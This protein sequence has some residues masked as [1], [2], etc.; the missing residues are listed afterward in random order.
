VKKL[1]QG[2]FDAV[3]TGRIIF[4]ALLRET[5]ISRLKQHFSYPEVLVSYIFLRTFSG[6]SVSIATY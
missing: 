2:K 3:H 1:F 6:N 5:Q 4:M